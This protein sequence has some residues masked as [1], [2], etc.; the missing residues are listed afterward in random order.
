MKE[1]RVWGPPGTGKTTW[2]ADNAARYVDLYG[3]D[4]VSICSL[5]NSAVRE[6]AG[7][8]IPIDLDNLSTLHAR[9]K[10]TLQAPPPAEV[11]VKDFQEAYPNYADRKHISVRRDGSRE[12]S[13][14]ASGFTLYDEVQNARQRLIPVER[15]RPDMRKWYSVWSQWCRESGL[16]DYSSWLESVAEMRCLPSQ[17]VVLVDEAQDHT[18]LQLKVLRSWDTRHLILVGDDDQSLYEWSGSVAEEFLR[19]N[20]EKEI[21][22]AQSYRVPRKVWMLANDIIRRVIHRKPKEYAPTEEEGSISGSGFNLGRS[23]SSILRGLDNGQDHMVLV[24]CS[25]MLK[26]IIKRLKMD[27]IPFHNPYRRSNSEWNPLSTEA[28]LAARSYLIGRWTGSSVIDWMGILSKSVF[29]SHEGLVA[30]CRDNLDRDISYEEI[31]P[32]LCE[33]TASTVLSR[34]PQALLELRSRSAQGSWGYYAKVFK[35]EANP[36]IIVGTIHS[37]KGGESDIVHI[38]PDLSLAGY[39]DMRNNPDRIHRLFY[40]A[41]TRARRSVVLYDAKGKHTYLVGRRVME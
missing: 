24:P 32:F 16:M 39:T 30:L 5:T 40:V 36:K 9:C 17:S 27:G 38:F 35:R 18:P 33:R 19:S 1:W 8:N 34:S 22:L 41:V 29:A 11:F 31:L 23:N 15:W 14:L 25:Y 28:A 37:V 20:A 13:I 10:R 21:V 12:E 6:V 2:I 3:P 26:G 7:R 4:Q